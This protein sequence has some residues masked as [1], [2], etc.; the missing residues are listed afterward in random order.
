MK[1]LMISRLA[2]WCL[3]IIGCSA[4]ITLDEGLPATS[5][6]AVP[7][8]TLPGDVILCDTAVD[9][10]GTDCATVLDRSDIIFINTRNYGGFPEA[11]LYSANNDSDTQFSDLTRVV[12]TDPQPDGL[13]LVNPIALLEIGAGTPYTPSPNQPGFFD[14]A[15]YVFLSDGDGVVPE[16]GTLFLVG[17]ALV[18]LASLRLTDRGKQPPSLESAENA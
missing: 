11:D 16:P 1:K 3:P 2:L 6:A 8:N 7:A 13:P 15:S 9:V 4:T 12:V 18:G 10:A 14:G 5:R 17:F